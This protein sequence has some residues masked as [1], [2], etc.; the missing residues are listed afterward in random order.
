MRARAMAKRMADFAIIAANRVIER[1][2]AQTENAF[3]VDEQ[4]ILNEIATRR[5]R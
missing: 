1:S 5:S 3:D 2:S 4:D